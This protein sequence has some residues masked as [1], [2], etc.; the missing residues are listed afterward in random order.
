MAWTSK[1]WDNHWGVPSESFGTYGD[2]PGS[3]TITRDY[4]NAQNHYFQFFYEDGSICF[5]VSHKF[6][7]STT[8]TV[9]PL[10]VDPG[11]PPV[12]KQIARLR[13]YMEYYS[14]SSTVIDVY[15][16]GSTVY[17]N[18][19]KLPQEDSG[20]T[21]IYYNAGLPDGLTQPDNN[22]E[23]PNLTTY[24]D[25][26]GRET[27]ISIY[28]PAITPAIYKENY[29]GSGLNALRLNYAN[30]T[31][32]QDYFFK[33]YAT[34]IGSSSVKRAMNVVASADSLSNSINFFETNNVSAPYSNYRVL[35]I[36]AQYLVFGIAGS[37]SVITQVVSDDMIDI[38]QRHCYG[39]VYDFT[40]GSSSFV[41]LYLDG[42]LIKT[43][44]VGSKTFTS[45]TQ[46][47]RFFEFNN[48]GEYWYIGDAAIS[49]RTVLDDQWMADAA[50]I[51]LASY[52]DPNP[53]SLSY[54]DISAPTLAGGPN[55]DFGIDP[56]IENSA[57]PWNFQITA[58]TLPDGL[59]LDSSTGVISGQLT[60]EV[61]SGDHTFTVTDV[62]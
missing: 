22:Y 61:T 62:T 17:Q 27:N 1:T 37:D 13:V 24:R 48:P 60:S 42:V 14:G 45:T 38:T 16:T 53:S 44:I 34:A 6:D 26:G 36:V 41:K 20:H 28:S 57:G 46:F 3:F 9:T 54:P 2:S 40:L 59:T 51:M 39:V 52:A 4:L 49:F 31:I 23:I 47:T 56:V 55:Y 18:T 43:T 25:V 8:Y 32:E 21:D 19:S 58:G 15:W 30:Q 11:N 10:S 33:P 12:H 35:S 7:V 29:W 5:G 50:A